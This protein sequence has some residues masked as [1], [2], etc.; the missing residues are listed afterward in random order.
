[1]I[2]C[3]GYKVNKPQQL[4]I[5]VLVVVTTSL[6]L[7]PIIFYNFFLTQTKSAT[8]FQSNGIMTTSSSSET[9][10]NRWAEN[11]THILPLDLFIF[12]TGRLGNNLL[13]IAYGKIIQLLALEDGRF[14]FTIQYLW[15][16][17]MKTEISVEELHT[18]FSKY[19]SKESVNLMEWQIGTPQWM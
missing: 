9:K 1:M 10:V 7:F 11:S 4:R 12:L 13:E 3:A 16:T 14:N 2:P 5:L 19:F 8:G 15:N 17:G 6:S 18:R